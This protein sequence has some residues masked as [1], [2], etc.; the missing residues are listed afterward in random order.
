MVLNSNRTDWQRVL[1]NVWDTIADN[2]PDRLGVRIADGPGDS[3]ERER[4]GETASRQFILH[5]PAVLT[6]SDK[7][8]KAKRSRT[9]RIRWAVICTLVIMAIALAIHFA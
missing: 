3:E 5:R 1:P 4:R 6:V 2:P 9:I 8:A 7:E